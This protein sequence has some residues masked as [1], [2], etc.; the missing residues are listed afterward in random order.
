MNFKLLNFIC[1]CLFISI[2]SSK[3]QA[4][5]DE[6]QYILDNYLELDTIRL[7]FNHL[8]K[9]SI[10]DLES[11]IKN[12]ITKLDSSK[13]RYKKAVAYKYVIT[14]NLE[15]RHYD[16][17]LE[18]YFKTLDLPDFKNSKAS[19][20]LNWKIL[21]LY[22]YSENTIGMFSQLAELRRL[23]ERYN[24]HRRSTPENINKVRGEILYR[25]G[26]LEEA[27]EF[28]TNVL[29]KDSLIYDHVRYAIINNDLANIY[30]RLFKPDSVRKYRSK[31][32]KYINDKRPS[33]FKDSYRTYIKY[34]IMLHDKWYK[35]EYTQESITFTKNFLTYS[36]EK[37]IGEPHSI[38]YA[39]Y[40]LATCH[41]YLN[42]Y[43]MAN[44][45]IE[46]AL[47]YNPS[48]ITV[49]KLQNL[50]QLQVRIFDALDK[51]AEA[52]FSLKR[53]NFVRDSVHANNRNLDL[54]KYEVSE[55]SKLKEKA[56]L[57]ADINKNKYKF[58]LASSLFILFLLLLLAISLYI[59]RKNRLELKIA[60]VEISKKLKEKGFLLKELNHRVKNNLSLILSLINFQTSKIDQPLIK[61]KFENLENRINTIAIAHNQFSYTDSS[62]DGQFYDLDVYISKIANALIS[63]SPKQIKLNVRIDSIQLTIDTALPIGIMINELISN[64]IEHAVVEDDLVITLIIKSFDEH[65]EITYQD[66]GQF[67]QPDP[68]KE[69]LGTMIIESMVQQLEG[70]LTRTN[71]HYQ[72]QIKHKI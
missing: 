16:I 30:D 64:S 41:F 63:L 27:R 48:T 31:S 38:I 28:Y 71:S 72:I 46:K 37:N 2:F 40:F 47:T 70:T 45:Y 17:A 33:Y 44:K 10:L 29:I 42:E 57:E 24:Y 55:I 9:D 15:L 50:Y 54:V 58:Y 34:F 51:K 67:F 18:Y 3:A 36:E 61:H 8:S 19:I 32:L 6:S 22:E 56:E 60:Q 21:K 13:D 43:Q 1:C 26:Y 12:Y 39:Y 68:K 52:D 65:I 25:V 49:N 69:S 59:S 23:G 5:Y 7:N 35:K 11:S 14:L 66:S 53:L 4:P 20:E 62:S